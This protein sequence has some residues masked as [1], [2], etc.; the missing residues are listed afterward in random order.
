MI[1]TKI[2]IVIRHPVILI[3][4][5]LNTR[6]TRIVITSRFFISFTKNNIMVDYIYSFPILQTAPTNPFENGV[7]GR[8]EEWGFAF[9]S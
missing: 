8:A 5:R 6:E 4:K 7:R 9:Y 3:K 2:L 1:F